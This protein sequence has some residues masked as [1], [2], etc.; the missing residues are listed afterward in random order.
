MTTVQLVGVLSFM[1]VMPLG[2]DFTI[3]LGIPPSE[4]G[5]IMA[6]YTV[7]SAAS[8]LTS[9]L[10]IDRFD[11]RPALAVALT[12]LVLANVAAAVAWDMQSLIAARIVSGLFG[13]P[14]AAL[15]IAVVAD[16]VPVERRGQ[17]MGMVM[18][19]ISIGAVFGI[20]LGLEIAHLFS[21]RAA[22][23]AVAVLGGVLVVIG[24]AL[25]PSQRLHLADALADKSNPAM[26]LIRIA[27]RRSTLMALAL[28]AV[29]IIPGFMVMTNLAVFAQFNLGFPREQLGL[30]YMIGGAV[31]F[32]GMRWS[33][34]FVDRFGSAPVTLVTT[35]GMA[36]T[37]WLIFVDRSWVALPLMLLVPA[38]MLFN[39]ARMVAQNTA[40][41]KVPDPAE[42]AGFMA[43]VQAC[44]QIFG[45][46]GVM[47]AALMLGTGPGGQLV[48]MPVVGI[49]AILVSL[50]GPFLMWRLERMIPSGAAASHRVKAAATRAAAPPG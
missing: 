7:A 41:S 38:T 40:V 24:V 35:L 48:N 14:A 46:I 26:R 16:N 43:L 25:L 32:F 12:G 15:S 4:V 33:G 42:R 13:G 22:F 27:M 19:A 2:P 49:L 29:A 11:R 34:Q 20:P 39:T 8:G 21:W 17:A 10:F 37:L 18:G 28:A 5:W 1:I 9:A 47:G 45:S 50:A 23:L 3:D 30:L 44:T 31:S 6:A 36:L